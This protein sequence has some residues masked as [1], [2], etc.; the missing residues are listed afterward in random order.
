MRRIAPTLV[1]ILLALLAPRG[2]QAIEIAKR[3]GLGYQG[4]LAGAHGLYGRFGFG[5]ARYPERLMEILAHD[6][7][8]RRP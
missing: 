1:V 3:F 4:T 6:P 2:A 5:A 8:G 7:Y